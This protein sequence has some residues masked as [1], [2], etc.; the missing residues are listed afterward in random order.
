MISLD[1]LVD[2]P[3]ELKFHDFVSFNI[4]HVPLK[5]FF[6]NKILKFCKIEKKILIVLTSKGPPFEKKN[7]KF[8][9]SILWWQILFFLPESEFYQFKLSFEIYNMSFSQ[10][11]HFL[12]I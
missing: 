2:A 12:F 11:F 8:I 4:F 1:S 10:N 6:F 3:N 7:F 9:F 5:P